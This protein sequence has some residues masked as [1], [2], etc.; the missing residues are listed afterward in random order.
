MLKRCVTICTC[1]AAG[2]GLLLFSMAQFDGTELARA[3]RKDDRGYP[4][5]V[6]GRL[7]DQRYR[8]DLVFN[9][10]FIVSSYECY[11]GSSPSKKATIF[12][13][14]LREFRVSFGN[15]ITVRCTWDEYHAHWNESPNKV[16]GAE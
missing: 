15:G 1:L 13:P 4:Y 11:A 3:T 14:D 10:R 9:N 5:T 6:T 8:T 16:F 12:W 7:I 2:I